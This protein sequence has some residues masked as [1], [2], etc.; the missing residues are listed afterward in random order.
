[1]WLSGHWVIRKPRIFRGKYILD[2]HSFEIAP[3][4]SEILRITLE[5]NFAVN[6]FDLVRISCFIGK[7]FPGEKVSQMPMA[8]KSLSWSREHVSKFVDFDGFSAFFTEKC[9]ISWMFLPIKW[10]PYFVD[11]K[12]VNGQHLPNIWTTID[13]VVYVLIDHTSNKKQWNI[14]RFH[15]IKTKLCEDDDATA[16]SAQSFHWK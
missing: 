1:M 12:I 5:G 16:F 9:T 4:A 8:N 15:E 3:R 2:S 6:I 14:S 11:C 7:N 13:G 10:H